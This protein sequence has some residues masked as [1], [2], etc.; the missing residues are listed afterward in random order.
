L[1][2]PPFKQ[3]VFQKSFS[4]RHLVTKVSTSFNEISLSAS[5][6][7]ISLPFNQ[8]AFATDGGGEKTWSYGFRV[9]F[10]NWCVIGKVKV[11]V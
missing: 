10:T 4:R 6:L 11:V 2:L 7:V 8:L 9:Y 3:A 1:T 5:K